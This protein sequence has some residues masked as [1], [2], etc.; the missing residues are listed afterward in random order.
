MN[1]KRGLFFAILC[2]TVVGCAAV[3]LVIASFARPGFFQSILLGRR[4]LGMS[5]ARGD[6]SGS[7]AD[8]VA[9]AN[10]GVVT[11]VAT[12]AIQADESAGSEN[13]VQRGTGAG[14]IVDAEGLIVTNH[15]VIVNADRIRVKLHDGRTHM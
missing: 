11:V 7:N 6:S 8:V 10:P 2:A 3:A 15:H 1:T 14:F 12:R 4:S 5:L 9:Q 13:R